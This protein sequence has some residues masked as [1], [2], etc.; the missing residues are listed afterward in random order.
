MTAALESSFNHLLPTTLRQTDTLA[1]DKTFMLEAFLKN[2]DNLLKASKRLQSDPDVI[3][4]QLERGYAPRSISK[5]EIETNPVVAAHVLA[6]S[7]SCRTGIYNKVH[8]DKDTVLDI[9]AQDASV[10]EALVKAAKLKTRKQ[11]AVWETAADELVQDEQFMIACV[12]RNWRAAS[13]VSTRH[14]HLSNG[15]W[16]A[17]FEFFGAAK[18]AAQYYRT[19]TM[20]ILLNGNI[21]G[22]RLPQ[23]E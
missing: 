5:H 11:V 1:D 8:I 16:T 10:L 22:Y 12:K 15:A 21:G 3:A 14:P 18:F 20:P 7:T 2:N 23:R 13:V 19:K 9:I 17:A 4:A 6:H